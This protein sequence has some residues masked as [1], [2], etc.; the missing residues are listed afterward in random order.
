MPRTI[1]FVLVG[2][3]AVAAV[4][5]QEL[6]DWLGSVRVARPSPGG[7]G[8]VTL[9]GEWI[10][11]NAPDAISHTRTG[12]IIDLEVTQPGL[13]VPGLDVITPWS[14]TEE[15]GPL[16]PGEFQIR[17][18]L[19]SVNPHNRSIRERIFGPDLLFSSFTVPQGRFHGLGALNGDAYVSE[20]FDVSADGHVV[21]GHNELAPGTNGFIISEAFAW[22][23]GTGMF[24]IGRLPGSA[25]GR[26]TAHG[27]SGDGNVVVGVSDA[28][29]GPE[30][31]R[32]TLGGGTQGLGTLPGDW[33]STAAAAS[34]DGSVVVG[35]SKPPIIFMRPI[36]R[37]AFRWTSESG[38]VGLGQV[39]PGGTSWATDVSADG[40]F[41]VGNATLDPLIE[42]AHPDISEPFRWTPDAGMV[43]LG[44]M[45]FVFA[46]V[47]DPDF[48]VQRETTAEAVSADETHIVG[49]GRVLNGITGEVVF[50][51]AY[52][53]TSETGFED[54]G[55]LPA[56]RVCLTEL[57]G[58]LAP[59]DANST[60]GA[61]NA[62]VGE[63]D[64]KA[65]DVTADGSM[66]VG[67]GSFIPD[68]SL[69][70]DEFSFLW[71]EDRGMR[72]LEDVLR[73]DYGLGMQGQLQ[74][75][76]L[77]SASAISADGTTIVGT[78]TNPDG[79]QE[80]W[81]VVLGPTT[82][83][84][85]ADFD[86][87][88]DRADVEILRAGLGITEGA[89]FVDGD[90]DFDGAVDGHD[91]LTLLLSFGQTRATFHPAGASAGA[92]PEPSA[93]VL[94]L[95]AVATCVV[96]RRLGHSRLASP[97]DQN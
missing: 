16:P 22:S 2:V 89:R 32:W 21:V 71:Q 27:V 11:S 41:V 68:G 76:D 17:G 79:V 80:A 64:F 62:L 97:G 82:I 29:S 83:P 66:I 15:F 39:H 90:F 40:N 60:P 12:S 56:C 95:A 77:G 8:A 38:M 3:V 74:G 25:T 31:F 37:E 85:D 33:L 48:A 42:I 61:F 24:P 54:L 78:G 65:V 45:P 49:T 73:N 94:A 87:D 5:G 88:V 44:Q 91:L 86:G 58:Q 55:G 50:G 7:I 36:R 93:F 23:P 35:D 6:P 53:W 57:D 28:G 47:V 1:S 30:A 10:D 69:P 20:A 96:R 4:Q 51:R 26:S 34:G 9:S 63:Y 84:G 19:V 18:T 81:R 13:G 72:L 59:R 52:R 70:G 43:G 67:V 75:W 46:A 14:L 92:V